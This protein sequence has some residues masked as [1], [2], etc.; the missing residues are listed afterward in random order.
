MSMM[1]LLRFNNILLYLSLVAS[2]RGISYCGARMC[3]QTN[4]HTFCQYPEGP[5]SKCMGYI[6]TP[7]TKEERA[8][9]L[10]RLN[11]RRSEAAIRRVPGTV[12]AGDMLKLRW[13]EELAREAQR[14]ADQ[15]RPPR[16]PEE[17]DVCR[18]LYSTSV[19]QC[20]ASVVGEAPGLHVESMV[21]LWYMQ[22]RYYRGNITY[23]IPPQCTGGFY[24]DFAQILWSKTYM[25]GCGRSRF[26]SQVKGRFRTVE[27]LVCN[28][29]PRGPAPA[30]PLW[31]PAAPGTACPPRSQRDR[32]LT[33]LCNYQ[34]QVIE[35]TN[36]DKPMPINE[37]IIL[38][39]VLE[40]EGNETLNYF[41]SLDEIY[42]TKLAVITM[43]DAMT[44]LRYNSLQKRDVAETVLIED[45]KAELQIHN[46]ISN[47]KEMSEWKLGKETT[48]KISQKANIIG[49]PR[50]YNIE[51]LNEVSEQQTDNVDAVDDVY[52]IGEDLYGD[53]EQKEKSNKSKLHEQEDKTDTNVELPNQND[54]I[55]IENELSNGEK[56][57]FPSTEND[58]SNVTAT[59][60]TVT[61]EM[62]ASVNMSSDEEIKSIVN[63]SLKDN[64]DDYLSDPETVQELQKAL[65]QMERSLAPKSALHEKVR[66]EIRN[67]P[68]G[69]KN[70]AN[71]QIPARQEAADKGPMI[72][73]ILR[74]MP[75]L[76]QYENSLTG[77]SMR[78]GSSVVPCAVVVFMLI[79]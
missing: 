21:D 65:E 32:T 60:D 27:R 4:V 45:A 68:T 13:V 35:N 59:M 43:K 79:L 58:S 50:T 40:I 7:L 72:N 39:T 31:S 41:G 18:D 38:T 67:K 10:A 74:Y 77:S 55:V 44:T 51:E 6:E 16:T 57:E 69:S 62:R 23:Y 3:G 25:V 15:C 71:T 49:R 53:Y 42:L 34:P 75:Y 37:Q 64:V 47:F 2:V 36:I 5:S 11:R 9:L 56:I 28:F 76:K 17:R 54:S 19:G 73:M 26:L 61:K 1:Q 33:A 22:G 63:G 24:G 46:N 78:A 12:P 14:W 8:R 30:R 52:D 29:A 70:A 20:V 66:R 48:I